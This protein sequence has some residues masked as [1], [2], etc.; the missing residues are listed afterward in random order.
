MADSLLLPGMDKLG[1][2]ISLGQFIYQQCDDLKLC[3]RQ[4][5]RLRS[6]VHSLLQPLQMLQAQG[7]QNLST[8]VTTALDRFQAVLEKA[9]GQIE[10]FRQKSS[11]YRFFTAGQDKILF[12]E[13]NEQLRDVWEAL[14]LVL[15]VDQR[16][17]VS[18]GSQGAH[19]QREDEQDA[20]EDWQVIQRRKMGKSGACICV[21]VRA[22]HM[23]VLDGCSWE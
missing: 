1:Q 7:K 15:Q 19:W 2:I 14:S 10:E 18:G 21:C 5:Q 6:R 9:K 12:R 22:V 11:I 13:V 8:E 17:L 23:R 16:M 4:C 20:E 3:R